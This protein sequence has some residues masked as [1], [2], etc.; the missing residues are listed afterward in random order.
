MGIKIADSE[1]SIE[2]LKLVKDSKI[3]KTTIS[4][5]RNLIHVHYFISLK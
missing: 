5:R 4:A 3:T 2:K 1:V